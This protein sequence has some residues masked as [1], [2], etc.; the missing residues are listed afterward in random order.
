MV[1]TPT[2]IIIAIDGHSS[3]GKSTLAKDLSQ[4]FDLL[5]ID[6]GAMYR[7]VT[8]YFIQYGIKIEDNQKIEE[9]LKNIDID[10]FRQDN[11]QCVCLNGIDVTDE[12]RTP[13]ISDYVSEVATVSSVRKK[14]VEQQRGYGKSKNLIM[15][16]RDIGTV[17]FP[18]ADLK[19][20][21]TAN[22]ETR[23]KRRY[24]ELI[25][26]SIPVTLEEILANVLKRDKIDSNREDSPLMKAN[27]AIVIDNT[28]LTRVQQFDV[29]KKLIEEI[30]AQKKSAAKT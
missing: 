25:Q 28:D 15:D 4:H 18:Q 5:Y 27:D 10:F 11:R 17:V 14:L 1:Q 26:K 30:F 13:E 9:A 7:C 24:L 8:L 19:L 23:A 12:I 2:N 21:L 6:T 3:C 16:G 20:F 22:A 29:C